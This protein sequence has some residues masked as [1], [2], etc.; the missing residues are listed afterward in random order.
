MLIN[1]RF[2]NFRSFYHEN[3]LS[4]EAVKDS[5]LREINTFS[6]NDKLVCHCCNLL[7]YAICFSF[8]LA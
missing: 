5:E 3:N 7:F 1:F 8:L 4:M 6:V 2:K